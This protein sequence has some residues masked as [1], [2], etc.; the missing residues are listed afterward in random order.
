M[1]MARNK[2]PVPGKART[3]PGRVRIVAGKWR[4]RRLPVRA[5]PGLRPTSERVRETLFNWLAPRIEGARCLDLYAGTGA[6]GFEALSRGASEVLFVEQS[7][8]LAQGLAESARLLDAAS[9]SVQVDDAVRF[10]EKGE[11]RQRDIVFLDPPF[12]D[13]RM[14]ELCRLLVARPWL[15]PGAAVYLEQDRKAGSLILP[16]GWRTAREKCAGNV[17]YALVTA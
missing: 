17:R 10:L 12:G 3:P 5:A 6:L 8:T 4:G 1:S 11:V 13:A 9:A 7:D 2:T 14:E 16:D 15:S